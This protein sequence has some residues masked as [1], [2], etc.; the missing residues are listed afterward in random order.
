MAT[1]M[2]LLS[3]KPIQTPIRLNVSTDTNFFAVFWANIL[4]KDENLAIIDANQK[5]ITQYLIKTLF[6]ALFWPG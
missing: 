2:F 1:E 4:N 3:F 5:K 6:P